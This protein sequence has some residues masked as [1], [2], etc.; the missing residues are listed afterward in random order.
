MNISDVSD[1]KPSSTLH[2]FKF[3]NLHLQA[4]HI[5]TEKNSCDMDEVVDWKLRLLVDFR[6]LSVEGDIFVFIVHL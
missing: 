2:L 6:S 4:H 1:N 5:S 3:N